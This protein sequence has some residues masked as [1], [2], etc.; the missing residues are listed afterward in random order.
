MKIEQI[1]NTNTSETPKDV[2]ANQLTVPVAVPSVEDEQ[3]KAEEK[4][5][6][7]LENNKEIGAVR[8][9][10][11]KQFENKEGYAEGHI[12]N[13]KML[14]KIAQLEAINPVTL[15]FNQER[16]DDYINDRDNNGKCTVVEIQKK[17]KEI[18]ER[19]D[20]DEIKDAYYNSE[21]IQGKGGY[22][23]YPVNEDTGEV[24]LSRGRSNTTGTPAY[25]AKLAQ[26]AKELG[27]K[28]EGE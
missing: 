14:D 27:L 20:E 10:I 6:K 17:L 1:L 18:I 25:K 26:K 4:E 13:P 2:E 24:F 15:E 9:D 28:I 5:K 7:E 8:E 21:V 3:K 16:Y 19:G 11:M 12:M 23:R 22:N